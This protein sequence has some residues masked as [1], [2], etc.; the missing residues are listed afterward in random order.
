MN[1]DGIIHFYDG[2]V[3]T[4]SYESTYLGNEINRDVN[5]AHE[6]LNKMQCQMQEVRCTW[7]KLNAYWK[8]TRA[9]KRW[10][11]ILYDA[12]IRS[13]LLYGLETIHLTPA[14]AKKLDAFQYRGL[15]KI[16]GMS[17]TYINRANTNQRLLAAASDAA[18]PNPGDTRKVLPFSRYHEERRAKLLGHILRSPDVD[19]LRQVSFT[20][21][22]ASRIDYGKKR[23]GRPRQNWVMFSKKYVYENKLHLPNYTETAEQD[24]RVYDAALRRQF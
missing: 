24:Q 6:I 23:V 11:I 7:L 19:P 5:I 4:K 18:F 2:T 12:I 15:R 3:L 9:T 16:M 20:P 22:T 21:S 1:N 17:S 14:L 13:K 8:A 10:K